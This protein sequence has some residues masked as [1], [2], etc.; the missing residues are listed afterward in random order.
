MTIF[1]FI[2]THSKLLS[3]RIARKMPSTFQ[4]SWVQR[5]CNLKRD[6]K[7]RTTRETGTAQ[8]TTTESSTQV[9]LPLHPHVIYS[10]FKVLVEA[11]YQERYSYMCIKE[12]QDIIFKKPDY[13][14]GSDAEVTKLLKGEGEKILKKYND[15]AA[16]DKLAAAQKNVDELTGVVENDIRKMTDNA[17]QLDNLQG[18]TEKMKNVSKEFQKNTKEVKD[19]MW[20]RNMKLMIILAVLIIGGA[21]FAVWWFFFKQV[22]NC[23]IF[24]EQESAPTL[25]CTLHLLHTHQ[26][27]FAFY[28]STLLSCQSCVCSFFT[29]CSQLISIITYHQFVA[30]VIAYRFLLQVSL[31][32]QEIH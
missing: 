14:L 1:L 21:G 22:K 15:P 23:P 28:I 13:H 3:R 18:K 27:P 6:R 4:E 24:Q 11:G 26:Y 19:I 9:S 7:S 8:L 16:W 20:W 29:I 25:D 17:K 5:T 12:F 30:L 31:I 2:L 10:T 32:E